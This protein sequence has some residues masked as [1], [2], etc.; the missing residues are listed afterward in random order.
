[1]TSHQTPVRCTT[2]HHHSHGLQVRHRLLARARTNT[3]YKVLDAIPTTTATPTAERAPLDPPVDTRSRPPPRLGTD[4][5]GCNNTSCPQPAGR[6]SGQPGPWSRPTTP[7]TV[8]QHTANRPSMGRASLT[9][10][11][12]CR[13]AMGRPCFIHRPF[14]RLNLPSWI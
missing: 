12:A 8:A 6:H 11:S 2:H 1:M 3:T 7:P 13:S 4:P 5:R 9:V 14:G 10:G